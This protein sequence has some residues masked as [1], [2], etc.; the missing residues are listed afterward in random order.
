M[1]ISSKI[2]G[3]IYGFD[4][5]RFSMVTSKFYVKDLLVILDFLSLESFQG[6]LM[7]WI[8]QEMQSSNLSSMKQRKNSLLKER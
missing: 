1:Y 5:N 6:K 7:K 3:K 4:M 8:L 2:M